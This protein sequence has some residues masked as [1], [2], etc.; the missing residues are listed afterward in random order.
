MSDFKNYFEILSDEITIQS[1]ATGEFKHH[2]F[3]EYCAELLE[4][5]G[6]V[7]HLD[8]TF[9]DR[10]DL[11]ARHRFKINGSYYD[12][13]GDDFN[14]IIAISDFNER[15]S[16]ETFT[17]SDLKNIFKYAD[18]FLQLCQDST[19]L[20]AIDE[21]SQGFPAVFT[22]TKNFK[23]IKTIKVIYITNNIFSGRLKELKSLEYLGKHISYQ[24]CDLKRL[25]DIENS[26]SGHEPISINLQ[27]FSRF[28]LF[29]LKASSISDEYESYLLALPG[30]V[31]ALI[32]EE[33]GARLLEQNV[34]TFL[35]A[36]GNVNK[37]IIDT[38]T[39]RPEMFFAYNNGLTATASSLECEETLQGLRVNVIEN[40]QIVNGGQTT[41][42][43]VYAKRKNNCDLDGVFVQMKLSVIRP[44]K[45]AEVVPR[46]S[47]YANTQNK[48]N[49]AD[50]FATHPFQVH[51]KTMCESISVPMREGDISQSYWFYE[52][53][54]GQYR[55]ATAYAKEAERKIFAVKYPKNQLILKTELARYFLS[56]ERCP[57]VVAKGATA[58]FLHFANLIGTPEVYEKTKNKYGENWI[59]ETISKVILFRALDKIIL[60]ADWYEGGGTKAAVATYTLAWIS[61]QI[62]EIFKAELH[63]EPVWKAQGITRPFEEIFTLVAE[64]MNR[65]LQLSAPEHV[66]SVPQWAKR[67]GCWD[68]IRE[69][70]FNIPSEYFEKISVSA[71]L[72]KQRKQSERKE[73]RKYNEDKHYVS[74][75]TMNKAVWEK[76]DL[77]IKDRKI[78]SSPL[79]AQAL[80]KVLL[81][82][83]SGTP[84]MA[85]AA[86]LYELLQDAKR[87]IDLDEFNLP[88]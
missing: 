38:V 62:K 37:G 29:A 63:L 11:D 25:S 10:T 14:F 18:R 15:G 73:T 34:R 8:A 12:S 66:K 60:K 59:K 16:P 77:A 84:T 75:V 33:Y 56:F 71:E 44:E 78:N 30:S 19:Y 80:R 24:L 20:D 23:K 47:E 36:K 1:V 65:A 54:R 72:D 68:K 55:D 13:D 52:R 17:T 35:Q 57:D 61:H 87:S 53:S 70:D 4:E 40:L 26:R 22:L 41:A 27:E 51:F 58:A 48:V 74:I 31:L 7:P 85:D 21:A 82:G 5:N 39:N 32:Y 49:A 76:I 43:I 88:I 3:F 86:K 67:K 79:K 45:I 6:D 64:K 2:K 50:F 69:Q 9:L 83:S 81:Q 28:P 46:I 42:S